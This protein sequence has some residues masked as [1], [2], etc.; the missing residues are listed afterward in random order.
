MSSG[1]ADTLREW[2]GREARYQAPEPIGQASIRYFALATGDDCVL[3]RDPERAARTAHGGLVAPP[4]LVCE[5]L[6]PYDRAPDT[7]GYVGH[8][9]DLPLGGAPSMRAGN[10]Y[11]F[12]RPVHPDD[13]ITVVWRLVE[14]FERTGADG[15][16]LLFVVS[17]AHYSNQ[18]GDPLAVNRETLVHVMRTAPADAPS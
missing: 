5:T 10:D 6:Q 17:E 11:T 9:W 7:D 2:I 13:R 18:H 15:A 1:W 14:L 4:T 3:Y 12:V 8:A 16:T